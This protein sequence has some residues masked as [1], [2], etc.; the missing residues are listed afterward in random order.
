MI[1]CTLFDT[2][3]SDFLHQPLLEETEELVELVDEEEDEEKGEPELAILRTCWDYSSLCL[4]IP[5]LLIIQFNVSLSVCPESV[6]RPATVVWGVALF[7][8]ATFL[9][10][11]SLR[12]SDLRFFSTFT[13]QMVILLPEILMDVVLGLVLV[14]TSV[15]AFE[16]LLWATIALSSLAIACT[17][18][19]LFLS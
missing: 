16:A 3:A 8:S 5:A 15:V 4:V 18:R 10:K 2:S 7:V 11:F 6:L 12:P 1:P 19:V 14:T 17:L 13:Q 9:Y